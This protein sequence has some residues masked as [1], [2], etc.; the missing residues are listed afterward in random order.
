MKKFLSGVLALTL[1]LA[2]T[3]CGGPKPAEGEAGKFK[4]G[5]YTGVGKG[6]NGDITVEVTLTASEIATITV[7]E[8]SESAGISDLAL[9]RLPADMVKGQTLAVDTVAG[10]T[11]SSNGIIAAVTAALQSAGV[12]TATLQTKGETTPAA[13]NL[14]DGTYDVVVVGAGGA[15]LSAA[16]E[17]K[18]NGA[19]K[20]VLIE[21]MPFAG[22]NTLLSYAELACA[23]NWLQKDKGIEDSNE[24]FAQEMWEGGGKLARKEMVDTVVSGALDGALWLRDTIGVKYQDYLVHEGGHSVPR[25]VEPIELGAGMIN[26]LV[27]YAEQVGVEIMYNTKAEELVVGA[28]GRVVGVKVSAGDQKATFTASSGVVLASGGFGANVEMRQ[29]Y[30]TRWETLDK[31]VQT[32][33]S[34]AILGEGIVMAEKIGAQLEGMEHIQLYPFNNPMTGVFYGIEAPSWSG[35]GL[36]YVNQDGN[37]FVNEVAM[38]DVRAEAILA[39]N[40]PVYAI[41][42]QAVA[43]RMGLEEKFASEYAKCLEGGVYYKADTLEEVAEYFGIDGKNLVTTMDNYNKYMAA[44]ADPEF[45]RTT[46]MV[47]MS[48]GGPWFILKGVVSVHHTMGGVK[49]DTS[50][51]VLDAGDK[52]IPGLYAAGE[53]TGSV[54]GNNRVGTCAISDIVVFGKIAGKSAASGK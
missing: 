43:D 36:I 24:I 44:G 2:L 31:T 25:A 27:A 39:Q 12:D 20:V 26:P 46:S 28:D 37:R 14:T 15:G 1:L 3:A 54:H 45:G 10:A 7:K 53:V 51:H 11:N 32:T 13:T 19:D 16:I 18:E 34:P 4:A 35:E 21:K 50:A 9:E 30:N 42:N 48:E 6:N 8:H 23:G 40:G 47:P 5:T 52:V 33:N 29:K 41:Y 38:R 22:G 17:A 49:I